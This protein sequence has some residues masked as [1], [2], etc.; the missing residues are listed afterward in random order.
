MSMGNAMSFRGGFKLFYHRVDVR[1][2]GA[3]II[4]KEEYI[5]VHQGSV[6][7][8]ITES[9]E[10]E[11]LCPDSSVGR[12][13]AFEQQGY[14]FDPGHNQLS[15]APCLESW[16]KCWQLMLGCLDREKDQMVEDEE[17]TK[18]CGAQGGDKKSS[19][20]DCRQESKEMRGKTKKKIKSSNGGR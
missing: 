9:D 12:A 14:G 2:N 19:Q 8:N 1:S 18:L 10:R 4:L 15:V 3:G 13:L 17:R 11:Y 16:V 5:K 20:K 7:E 6:E